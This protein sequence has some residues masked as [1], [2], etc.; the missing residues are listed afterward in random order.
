MKIKAGAIIGSLFCLSCFCLNA[1]VTEAYDPFQYDSEDWTTSAREQ[2]IKSLNEEGTLPA[3]I[4]VEGRVDN[5]DGTYSVA[6]RSETGVDKSDIMVIDIDSDGMAQIATGFENWS[7]KDENAEEIEKAYQAIVHGTDLSQEELAQM[8][9]DMH[10]GNLDAFVG[11]IANRYD[12][13]KELVARTVTGTAS[14]LG[15]IILGAGKTKYEKYDDYDGDEE[16][17][18]SGGGYGGTDGA[19]YYDGGDGSTGVFESYIDEANYW[20]MTAGTRRFLNILST[21]YYNATGIILNLTSG[22]RATDYGSYHSDGIAF[23]VS[24][25]EFEGEDGKYYRDLYCQMVWEMG[26]TPLD[27][28]PGEPGEVY[29]NG[30]NIH[31][32]V[33]NHLDYA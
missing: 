6:I 24:N 23:D 29:A 16:E 20:G 14:I 13:S 33:H 5:G 7:F 4:Q 3:G 31:V 10:E 18:T 25:A 8:N 22:L 32:S 27:E 17:S 2:I 11:D 19:S 9:A 28:Y 26:G 15:L 21:R 30:S 12:I 1:S